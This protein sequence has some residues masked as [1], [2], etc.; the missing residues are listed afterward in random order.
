MHNE[1]CD[2]TMLDAD[3]TKYPCARYLGKMN[4]REVLSDTASHGLYFPVI[5]SAIGF[6]RCISQFLMAVF[7]LEFA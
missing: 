2:K 3:M 1:L 7:W 4:G 6:C 5:V